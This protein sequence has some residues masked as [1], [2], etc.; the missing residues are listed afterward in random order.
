VRFNFA[1]ASF[2]LAETGFNFAEAS[3]NFAEAGF[4]FAGSIL[5]LQECYMKCLLFCFMGWII[6]GQF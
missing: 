1:E 6:K 4:I 5:N 2:S 3:F